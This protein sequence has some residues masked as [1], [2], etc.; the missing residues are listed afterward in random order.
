MEDKICQEMVDK[1][2]ESFDTLAMAAEA[3]K[4]TYE[5][6]AKTIAALTKTNA[7]LSAIN[8]KLTDKIVTLSEQ[9]LAKDSP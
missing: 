3:S 4:S 6:Q 2:G 5:E 8:K 7:E 9:L 1:M